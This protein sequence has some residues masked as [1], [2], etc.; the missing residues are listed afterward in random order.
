MCN[1]FTTLTLVTSSDTPRGSGGRWVDG[2]IR[3]SGGISNLGRLI[4]AYSTSGCPLA[5]GRYMCSY[6]MCCSCPLQQKQRPGSE[7]TII[8][9]RRNEVLGDHFHLLRR[10]F[11]QNKI[12]P[13]LL[14]VSVKTIVGNILK[15]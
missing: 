1:L 11:S 2:L 4:S 5:S 15:R 14:W 7:E 3:D 10:V 9:S 12:P 6:R 13:L 8:W